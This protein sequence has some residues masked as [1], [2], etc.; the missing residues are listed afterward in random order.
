MFVSKGFSRKFHKKNYQMQT[1]LLYL[2]V[3]G[4]MY[5]VPTIDYSCFLYFITANSLLVVIV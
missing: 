5:T 3:N 4:N 1:V 2:M